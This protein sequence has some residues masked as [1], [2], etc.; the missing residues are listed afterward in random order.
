MT[1]ASLRTERQVFAGVLGER[2]AT[3]ALSVH[4]QLWQGLLYHSAATGGNDREGGCATLLSERFPTGALRGRLRPWTAA[5]EPPGRV[6]WR[7]SESPGQET[8]SLTLTTFDLM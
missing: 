3:D 6:F 7:T 8:L 5:A 4:E 2:L 1:V